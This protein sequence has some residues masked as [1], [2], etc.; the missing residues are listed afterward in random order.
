MKKVYSI[1]FIAL[2]AWSVQDTIAQSQRMV[3]IEKGS[4]ASCAPCAAQN[5]G[6]HSMLNTV[7]D[8]YVGIS[9]QWYFPGYDPMNE[10]NPTEA[11]A[12][13]ATY[14]GNNGV[15]TAMIDGVVPDGTY[16]GF[17]GSAYDGAPA[18]YSAQMINN[19]YEETSPFDIDI[20]YSV[21]PST[22]SAE[23][24]VTCTEAI[25]ANNLRL[26]IAVIEEVIDFSSPPGSNGESTFYNVMKKFMPST[27]GLSLQN[28]WM[29]GDSQTFSQSW[30]HQNIYDFNEVAIVAF[31]QNDT[32]KEVLQAARANEAVFE[33]NLSNAA[34]LLNMNVP[35]EI[36]SGT[37]TLSPQ[38]TL[39]N[40]GNANLT[41][42]DIV[43][44][45]NG[46]EFVQSWTGDLPLMGEDVV[47][48]DAISFEAQTGTNTL[49]VS[50]T[51]TN[52]AMNEEEVSS[53][54][55]AMEGAADGGTAV[56]VT[57]VTDNYGDETYW[58][59]MDEGGNKIAEGGNPNVEN[60]YGTGNFPP[61]SGAGTYGN[62]QT[63]N[64]EVELPSDGCYT[65]EIFDYFGD[66]LCCQYGNGSYT[67]RNLETNAII[68]QGNDFLDMTDGKFEGSSATSIADI[69]LE[70]SLNIYPNPV[71]NEA[72]LEIALTESSELTIDLFDLTGKKVFSQSYGTQPA[73]EF[74]TR[75]QFND[76]SNG[77]YLL[78]LRAGEHAVTRKLSVNK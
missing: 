10:H 3:L 32:G 20:T 42:C 63:N 34:T 16:P 47:T 2:L 70:G 69:L 74:V 44:E 9:Y 68:I 7:D 71:I 12:R 60:N 31:V 29:P 73:G 17:N 78:N 33:S 13:F 56:L 26:R 39:R 49:T 1:L 23:V 72:V 38:F 57:I 4:N 11:N 15:P 14:Y 19:R 5:P 54:D 64:H 59:I 37:N 18:G 43:A 52:N 65:F 66:G 75:L 61:P 36:C 8:K 27:A 50:I 53:V 40:T 62:G 55:A 22:I 21:T 35:A 28:A 67:V 24:T 6:F 46:E 58:R 51:N 76:V 45:I 48:M 25:T 30:A 77:M 41:S